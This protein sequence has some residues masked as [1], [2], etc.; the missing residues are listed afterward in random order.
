MADLEDQLHQYAGQV[1]SAVGPVASGGKGTSPRGRFPLVV[2]AAALLVVVAAFAMWFVRNDSESDP[3]GVPDL[4]VEGDST[5]SSTSPP[6]TQPPPLMIAV[7]DVA[8]LLQPDAVDV[9]IG[10]GL[11]PLR[12]VQKEVSEFPEGTVLRTHPVAGIEVEEAGTVVLIVS[13]GPEVVAIP[14]VVVPQLDG[15]FAD[16]AIK[17]LRDAGFEPVVVFEAVP[18]GSSLAGRVLDQSPVALEEVDV[19]SEITLTVGEATN[20]TSTT[21]V[22]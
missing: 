7:P 22:P 10:A 1:E 13:T 15:L 2:A 16:I 14:D 3:A 20:A 4:I 6:P 5:T 9:L 12:A 8:G 21:T 17:A 11:N 19:G 18:I